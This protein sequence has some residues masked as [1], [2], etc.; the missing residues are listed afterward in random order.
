MDSLLSSRVS[1]RWGYSAE[2]LEAIRIFGRKDL[3]EGCIVRKEK[4][5]WFKIANIQDVKYPDWKTYYKQAKWY[6][7]HWKFYQPKFKTESDFEILGHKVH[8][9]DLF[10]ACEERWLYCAVWSDGS[11]IAIRND[12]YTIDEDFYF[13]SKLQFLKQPSLPEILNLFK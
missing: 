2:Q 3:T 6:W 1:T 13:D 11:Y 12:D 8:L 4:W 9:E 7:V 5:K 10:R